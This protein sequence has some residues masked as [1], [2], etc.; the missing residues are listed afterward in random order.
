MTIIRPGDKRFVTHMD[1]GS[2]FLAGP[3]LRNSDHD[4]PWR[5]EAVG[6]LENFGFHGA[7]FIPEPFIKDYR[8]QVRWEHRAL[9][10]VSCIAF[11]IPRDLETLPGFTTNVEFGMYYQ[12]PRTLVGWPKNAPKTRYLEH[13]MGPARG[14]ADNVWQL[15]KWAAL[16]ARMAE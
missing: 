10:F 15:M 12:D 4:T 9:A 3:T 6:A 1:E 11:W 5:V 8:E 7:L 16:Q 13:C 14:V 2:I